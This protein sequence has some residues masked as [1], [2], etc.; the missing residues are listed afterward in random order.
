MLEVEVAANT[1]YAWAAEEI[2][3]RRLAEERPTDPVEY[4]AAVRRG[5]QA[6]RYRAHDKLMHA[7]LDDAVYDGRLRVER[8]QHRGS[9]QG[10]LLHD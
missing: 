4:A 2:L 5:A 8:G 6:L 7:F 10:S 1:V 3:G 9:A